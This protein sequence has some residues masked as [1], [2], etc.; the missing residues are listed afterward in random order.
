MFEF[1]YKF[2]L[3]YIKIL[4]GNQNPALTVHWSSLCLFVF[5]VTRS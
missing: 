2:K 4:F 3:I 1:V 5:S